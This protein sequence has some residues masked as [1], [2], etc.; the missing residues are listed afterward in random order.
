MT[1]I[2]TDQLN[3]LKDELSSKGFK[4]RLS[5]GT[6]MFLN[7]AILQGIELDGTTINPFCIGDDIERIYGMDNVGNEVRD[8]CKFIEKV[9]N[10]EVDVVTVHDGEIISAPTTIESIGDAPS[11]GIVPQYLT[12]ALISKHPGSIPSLISMQRTDPNQIKE[13]KSGGG[14]VKYVDTAYM[15]VALNWACLMDW[16]FHVLETREDTIDKKRHFTVLGCLVIH[17]TEGKK[18]TKQQFGSAVLKA[19]QETGDC[20]KAAASDSLKK[21]ASQL[22]IAADVYGGMV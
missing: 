18:I 3:T 1:K 10:S 16:D 5:N 6:H 9:I 22:G 17:T 13:R 19:K 2:S 7:A 4:Y 21:C 8:A 11:F 20:L 15:T 14:M 12:N